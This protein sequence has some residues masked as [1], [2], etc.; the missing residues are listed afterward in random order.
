MKL[1]RITWS[2]PLGYRYVIY[3]QV[4]RCFSHSPVF[5]RGGDCVLLLL[6]SPWVTVF[7]RLSQEKS[8][9]FII[10]ILI[11]GLNEKKNRVT[12]SPLNIMCTLYYISHSYDPFLVYILYKISIGGKTEITKQITN[13]LSENAIVF[14][15]TPSYRFVPFLFL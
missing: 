10:F 8:F 2:I 13:A 6:F 9:F 5:L 15:F 3:I 11:I 14:F 7:T 4:L 1:L 12:F